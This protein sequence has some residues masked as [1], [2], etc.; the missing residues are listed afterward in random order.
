MK[1]NAK[2]IQ[3]LVFQINTYYHNGEKKSRH[4]ASGHA[5]EGINDILKRKGDTSENISVKKGKPGGKNC[6]RRW[7]I[8]EG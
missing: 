3:Y 7:H 8:F 4:S 1:P 2:D 5:Y 6:V